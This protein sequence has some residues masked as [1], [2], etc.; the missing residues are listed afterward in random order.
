MIKV[1]GKGEKIHYFKD[2]YTHHLLKGYSG[3]KYQC[4]TKSSSG[5][6][7]IAEEFEDGSVIDTNDHMDK[8]NLNYLRKINFKNEMKRKA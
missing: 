3:K 4:G 5:C 2:G 7:A 6:T 1:G 8:Q